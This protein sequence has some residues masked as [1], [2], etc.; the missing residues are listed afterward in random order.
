MDDPMWRGFGPLWR[1]LRQRIIRDRRGDG[2][3]NAFGWSA[4]TVCEAVRRWGEGRHVVLRVKR[5]YQ[6]E[7]ILCYLPM[8]TTAR[9]FLVPYERQLL[10]RECSPSESNGRACEPGPQSDQRCFELLVMV[11]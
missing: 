4:V 2:Y 9:G 8:I 7:T 10:R 1:E 3:L 5:I 11:F 6:R